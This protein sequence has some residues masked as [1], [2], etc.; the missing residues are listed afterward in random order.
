MGLPAGAE[1]RL[2]GSTYAE[3]L[4]DAQRYKA[5]IPRGEVQPVVSQTT[6]ESGTA[7]YNRMH[8]LDENGNPPLPDASQLDRTLN[9]ERARAMSVAATGTSHVADIAAAAAGLTAP[10]RQYDTANNFR[11]DTFHIESGR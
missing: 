7:R 8:G 4:E 2:Q 6:T 3:L 1:D 11:T 9:I 5:E 10:A